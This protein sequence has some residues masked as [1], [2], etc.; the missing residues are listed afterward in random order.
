MN[1]TRLTC[2][3]LIASACALAA[4]LFINL[5]NK[6]LLPSAQAEMVLSV[7]QNLSFLTTRTQTGEECLFV[8]DNTTSKL[9]IYKLDGSRKRLEM[10]GN[11]DL[12]K[13]F[14]VK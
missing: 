2:M 13:H 5:H 10:V 12:A 6:N 8:I 14:R 4:A 11:E 9:L 1:Q 7:G 3:G